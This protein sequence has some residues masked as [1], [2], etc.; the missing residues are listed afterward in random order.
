VRLPRL[1]YLVL[2]CVVWILAST[3]PAAA[4]AAVP[5][6]RSTGLPYW[7]YKGFTIAATSQD[8]LFASGPTLRAIKDLGANTVTFA[9]TWYTPS[10]RSSEIMATG[11]TATDA[12]LVWAIR[13]ARSL[14]LTVVLKPHLDSEDGQWRAFIN[15]PDAAQWFA[16]YTALLDHYATLAQ[17]EGVRLLCIGAELISMSTNRAYLPRWRVLIASARRRFHGQLTYSANWGATTFAEEF[18]RVAFWDA[19]DYLGI[20]AYF[21]LATTGSPV[22]ETARAAWVA[23]RTTKIWPEVQRWRK[24]ILFTEIGYRS[25]LGTAQHPFLYADGAPL[26]AQEQ[27]AC[28]GGLF[29]AW[30][31]VPWLAGAL[32]WEWSIGGGSAT[33]TGYDIAYKP[34][35]AV[36]RAWFHGYASAVAPPLLPANLHLLVATTPLTISGSQVVQGGSLTGWA[37]IQNR[38]RHTMTLWRITIAARPPSG[39]GRR[40]S[41]SLG[42]VSDVVLAPGQSYTLAISRVFSTADLPG[43][44]QAYLT[45]QTIYGS[46]HS[47]GRPIPFTLT[48]MPWHAVSGNG[49]IVVV[50]PLALSRQ[51]VRRGET[52]TAT[53]TLQ[54]EGEAAVTLAR[55]VI[56]SR[57]PGGT[58]AG[59]PFDDFGVRQAITLAPEQ[60]YTIEETRPFRLT[61]PVGQW[62]SYLTYQTAGGAWFDQ[63]ARVR[64]RLLS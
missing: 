14:G 55:I 2:A 21:P 15:P 59:G 27:A 61:D 19:L 20:S 32:F 4:Q 39:V 7:K 45:V 40:A 18:P 64:F 9:V 36:V 29:Q 42:A 26:N 16:H 23:W 58:N 62:Y 3:P 12:S 17:Q 37:T 24:P 1:I 47:I 54:N 44:W 43:R 48:R 38:S 49:R 11:G 13:A 22:R 53:A 33:D 63:P 8:D 10:V 28:Y 51:V 60:R 34:V 46:W 35:A 50:S 57:P 31:S 41:N 30:S 6:P 5:A 56:T 25:A 52:V